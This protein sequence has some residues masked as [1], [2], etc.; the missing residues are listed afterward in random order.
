MHKI[1]LKYSVIFL[2]VQNVFAM[3]PEASNES[4]S[5]ASSEPVSEQIDYAAIKADLRIAINEDNTNR[6]QQLLLACEV[7]EDGF[8]TTDAIKELRIGNLLLTSVS[9]KN[10]IKMI[11][12]VLTRCGIGKNEFLT[13]DMIEILEIDMVI[14]FVCLNNIDS[15]DNIEAVKYLFAKCGI[16]ENQILEPFMVK[17]LGIAWAISC[18][19]W[20]NKIKKLEYL[21]LKCGVKENELLSPAMIDTLKINEAIKKAIIGDSSDEARDYLLLKCGIEKDGVLTSD[22]IRV[23]DIKKIFTAFCLDGEEDG[24]YRIMSRS[25]LN[26]DNVHGIKGIL[27]KCG[28]RENDFLTLDMIKLLGI[29]EALNFAAN[30]GHMDQVSYLLGKIAV[31]EDGFLTPNMLEAIKVSELLIT[32]L[33]KDDIRLVNYL[34]KIAGLEKNRKLKQNLKNI[35]TMKQKLLSAAQRNDTKAII[36]LLTK[37]T[38]SEHN[39]LLDLVPIRALNIDKILDI[40]ANKNNT[41]IIKFLFIKCGN[42]KA[43]IEHLLA[44]KQLK[45]TSL[46]SYLIAC[47]KNP[48]LIQLLTHNKHIL[49]EVLKR[50]DGYSDILDNR[51]G[52]NWQSDTLWR[53]EALSE[54]LSSQNIA[55]TR[56][57]SAHNQRRKLKDLQ[58]ALN[59]KIVDPNVNIAVSE[60]NSAVDT[61]VQLIESNKVDFYGKVRPVQ[62]F[63]AHE[64]PN[65]AK[66]VVI[67]A[68]GAMPPQFDVSPGKNSIS[69]NHLL[70]NVLRAFLNLSPSGSK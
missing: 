5:E 40:A 11:E 47:R 64:L 51:L 54:Q 23:L 57:I 55:T 34:I 38:I 39:V 4:V 63:S 65:V 45:D 16:E 3:Q 10:N 56:Q 13:P 21:L 20:K 29:G 15:V 6:V 32:L 8:L 1:F 26:A 18:A 62:K 43:A 28:V 50:L 12:Y 7:G 41:E 37:C 68:Q 66:P 48:E 67:V 2:L 33:S 24:S 61:P 22:M 36:T 42:N 30:E 31:G 14:N 44:I 9:K 27:E 70:I 53:F 35:F 52:E 46:R 69:E 17:K 25:N 19:A 58:I 49:H 60:F 59:T